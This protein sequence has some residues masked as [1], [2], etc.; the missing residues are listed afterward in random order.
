MRS[1]RSPNLDRELETLRSRVRAA[2]AADDLATE[3]SAAQRDLAAATQTRL[4]AREALVEIR[5]QRLDGM[6][7]EIALKLAVGACCPVC[8]SAEHP[9][10]ASRAAGAPD[11]AAEREARREVDDLEVVVE[12]HAQ[13]VR[14]LETRLATAL[15]EAGDT[16]DR[17]RAA[18]ADTLARLDAARTAAATADALAAR[19]DALLVEQRRPRASA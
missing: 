2:R 9:S 15:A 11:E 8:G 1:R 19:Q 6:A 18:Q 5:E 13:Q 3:L 17:L 12:A 7:A 4:L 16:V 10:P 14:G